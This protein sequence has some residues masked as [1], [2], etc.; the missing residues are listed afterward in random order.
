MANLFRYKF[1]M[2][3]DSDDRYQ[4]NI[5]QFTPLV[6]GITYALYLKAAS[7]YHTANTTGSSYLP[8]GGGTDPGN[9]SATGSYSFNFANVMYQYNNN[10]YAV[11]FLKMD[12]PFNINYTS[13]KDSRVSIWGYNESGIWSKMTIGDDN[14]FIAYVPDISVGSGLSRLVTS[15]NIK[16]AVYNGTTY[17]PGATIPLDPSV[18]NITLVNQ[19]YTMTLNDTQNMKQVQIGD[20]IYKDFPVTQTLS[21]NTVVNMSGKD[22]PVIT[23]DYTNTGKPTVTNTKV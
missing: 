4:F 3:V 12:Y 17:P 8:Q 21:E 14:T 20:T 16:A 7:S 18:E 2:S 11:A 13:F 22:D 6:S 19:N 23:V 10:F 15:G 1:L 9:N 5:T